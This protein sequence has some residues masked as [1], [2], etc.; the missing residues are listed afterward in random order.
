V[1]QVNE[2][3]RWIAEPAPA[4]DVFSGPLLYVTETWRDQAPLLRERFA[5]VAPVAR[6]PRLQNG[7]IIEEYALY[8]VAAP[9]APVLDQK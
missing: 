9:K 4:P 1:I 3:A 8:R 2:R 7:R 6:I 5:A